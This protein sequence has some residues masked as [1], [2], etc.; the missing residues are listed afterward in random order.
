MHRGHHR[1]LQP[2]SAN[3][4][5]R[6]ACPQTSWHLV[7]LSLCLTLLDLDVHLCPLLAH[8]LITIHMVINTSAGEEKERENRQREQQRKESAPP[9]SAATVNW[10]DDR[11]GLILRRVNICLEET[12]GIVSF[13]CTVPRAHDT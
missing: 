5:S 3:R 8:W 13:V 12:V 9:S 11:Y 10:M 2:G 1:A 7:L 4:T 6:V